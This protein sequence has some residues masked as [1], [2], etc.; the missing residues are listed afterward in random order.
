MDFPNFY[1]P[2]RVGALYTPDISAAT[3]AGLAADI[4]PAS[5]DQTRTLLLLVDVQVDFVHP[6]GSLAVPGAVDDLQRTIEWIYRHIGQ[7]TDITASLDSHIP[8]QIF[9]PTWWQNP[10]GEH[11]DPFTVV[12]AADV[13]AGTWQ[14]VMEPDWSR[15]YVTALETRAKKQL[16]IWPYHT[17][18]GT[19]GQAL[20]PALYEAIA[21]H[22]AARQAQPEMLRKGTIPKSEFYSMLEPELKVNDDPNGDI[23]TDLLERIAGYDRVYVTGQAK[24]HC[25]LETITSMMNYFEDRPDVIEKIHLLMDGTS[26]IAHPEIDFDALANETLQDYA[27]RGLK[28]ITTEDDLS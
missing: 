2:D 17:M 18:I 4:P 21:Y 3:N 22:A 20:M 28:L 26:V 25:V 23:N 19:Q 27:D 9:Y 5:D 15:G 14:P 16:M 24:S 11:P 7:I 10:D 12:S 1:T 13:A 6:E 8:Y